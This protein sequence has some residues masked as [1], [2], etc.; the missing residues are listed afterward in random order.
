VRGRVGP[1][2]LAIETVARFPNGPVPREDGLHWDFPALLEHSLA[3]L[4]AAG[5]VSSIGV[6]SWAVDYGLVRG[7]ELLDLPW[8][9]RDG[10]TA[11]G[12]EAVHGRAGPDEL[13][14]RTGLQFLAFNTIY[15]LAAERRLAEAERLLLVPDLVSWSLTGRAVCERTNASTTGLLDVHTRDWDPELLALVGLDPAQ[16]GELVDPGTVVG[17]HDGTPVVAVGSHD[18]ASA[19]VGVPMT[20]PD[21]AYVSCGTWGLV[22][23]ELD[24]PVVTGAGR[25]ANFTN[26]GG[27]DGRTR[28]LTNVMGTWLLSE[29]LR[30]WGSATPEQQ[31]LAALLEQAAAHDTPVPIFDVQDPRFVPPGDMPVR[32]ADWCREHD[33]PVPEGRVALVRSIV[34]SLAEGFATAVGRA[35]QLSGR[36]VG[37]VHVVGG[38]AQNTLLCRLLADRLGLPVL[39][40]PVEATALGNVLVQGRALG[41]LSGSLEDLRALVART[42]RIVRHEPTGVVR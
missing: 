13:Y 22:G 34:A 9:Y 1:D 17:D 35:A 15:Q 33:Q 14:R 41:A 12:V 25:A 19:V 3:G 39:A 6:D 27:V 24:A 38:G 5:P 2:T 31:S 21:A 23:V 7:G 8:C 42:Q 40:G 18:T 16:L 26:E 29:T 30:A 37:R 4:R 20:E 28:F 32:I 36:D 11:A 10:R